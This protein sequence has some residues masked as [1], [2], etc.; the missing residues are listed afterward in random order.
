MTEKDLILLIIGA[1]FGGAVSLVGA[2]IFQPLLENPALRFLV[3]FLVRWAPP[4]KQLLAGEWSSVWCLGEEL[5]RDDEMIDIQLKELGKWV[6]GKFT[7]NGREYQLLAKR[8]SNHILTGTYEDVLH[9]PTFHGAFQLAI[10]PGGQR[11]AGRWVGFNSR[12]SVISGRWDWRRQNESVYPFEFRAPIATLNNPNRNVSR[13]DFFIAYATPDRQ[14]AQHLRWC[15]QDHSCKV[16]LDVEDLSPG[17]SWPLALQAA[18]EASRAIVMLVSTHTN[19]AFYQ[20]EEIV[21]AIQL[22]RDKPGAHTVIPVI[23]EKLPQGAVSMPYGMRSLQ[24]QDATR[25]G[26][27]KRVA[28]ELVEWLNNHPIGA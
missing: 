18:M 17:A 21:Q 11:M 10:F 28:T 20:Q 3:R 27:L 6:T 23:L 5:N 15:L 13:Y 22:A 9:G 26:S 2:L 24:A 25:A 19:D 12:N 4:K 7:W 16:F 14:Q 8:D 1:V